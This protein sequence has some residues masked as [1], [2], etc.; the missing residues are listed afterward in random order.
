MFLVESFG[1]EVFFVLFSV[2]IF[3]FLWVFGF[4]VYYWLYVDGI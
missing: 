1:G 2:C 3:I 4:D